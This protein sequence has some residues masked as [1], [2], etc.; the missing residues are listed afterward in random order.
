MTREELASLLEKFATAAISVSMVPQWTTDEKYD[1][2]RNS[3]DTVVD[4][5]M[6][7]T[8]RNRLTTPSIN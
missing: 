7:C 8:D 6:F 5:V 1:I 4:T 3:L 2:I